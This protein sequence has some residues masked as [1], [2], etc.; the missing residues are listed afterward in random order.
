[1]AGLASTDP[2]RVGALARLSSLELAAGNVPAAQAAFQATGLTAQQCA[3][4]DAGPGM[5]RSGA[6]SS[7]FPRE[8]MQWG[9]EGWATIEHDVAADGR[10][11]N[12]RAVIAYPPFVFS[13]AATGIIKET[14]YEQSYR[15]DGSLGC[16]GKTQ[17]IV[18]RMPG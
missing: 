12:Q 8:A 3:L 9:F 14:R 4:I 11:L 2:I 18:F 7:D 13:E 16:G 5:K 10:T 1:M 17:R 6:Q 15:P